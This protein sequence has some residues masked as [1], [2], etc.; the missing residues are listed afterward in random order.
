[1]NRTFQIGIIGFGGFGKFLHH[2]WSHLENVHVAAVADPVA[3]KL[4]GLGS[5]KAFSDWRNMLD[6]KELDLLAIATVP[7]SHE[8]IATACMQAGKHLLIEKPLAVVLADARKI[9]QVRDETQTVA[10]IDLIMRFN[11][12]L[13]HLSK[14]TQQGVWGNLR[15]ID[16]E[17]YAQD[18]QLP[19]E[20]WFWKTEQSGGILIEHAVHFIDLSHFL[21]PG[22]VL[23]VNGLKHNRNDRQEDQIMANVLY[24]GGLIATHYH[25]FS[26]PGFFETTK[27]K[28]A[29]DLADIELEG[30]IPLRAEVRALV[31]EYTK[32][33]LQN[34]PFFKISKAV[35][36]DQ[37]TDE[38]RP[39]GWGD[40]TGTSNKRTIQSA[41]ISYEVSEMIT[42]TFDMQR[43]KQEVYAGCVQASLSDVLQKIDNPG[44]E[45]RAPLEAG[46]ES[47]EVAVRATASAREMMLS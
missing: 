6:L 8:L 1:M 22:K 4:H 47:L 28:L 26:R 19:P 9:I 23:A 33:V 32:E 40:T 17:N 39:D 16:V 14:L 7:S 11:P 44:H 34:S 20:H 2:H 25:S 30:W 10:G 37:T 12:L 27:I 36:V 5:A 43:S 35:S 15:R 41:G 21:S 42:G 18:E 13:E 38:S 46:L 31:N 24:E 29:Y 45:L 3:S